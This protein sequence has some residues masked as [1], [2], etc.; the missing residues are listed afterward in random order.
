MDDRDEDLTMARIIGV[1]VGFLVTLA[2]WLGV[3]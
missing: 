2:C 1:W 3:L